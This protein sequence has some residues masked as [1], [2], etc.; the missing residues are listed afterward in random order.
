MLVHSCT[1]HHAGVG[2]TITRLSA[3]RRLACPNERERHIEVRL[4]ES[5]IRKLT[6]PLSC[7]KQGGVGVAV[8]P[9]RH[10]MLTS[11]SCSSKLCIS[12]RVFDSCTLSAVGSVSSVLTC[13]Q[14]NESP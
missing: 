8:E 13:Q 5:R 14:I 10:G 1:S 2:T 9:L 12:A 6:T 3:R 4:L 7:K 11:A